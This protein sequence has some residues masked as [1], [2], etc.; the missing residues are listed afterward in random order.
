MGAPHCVPHV[1]QILLLFATFTI[2]PF[3]R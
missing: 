2:A 1:A 3:K